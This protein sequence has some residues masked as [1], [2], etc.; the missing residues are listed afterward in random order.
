MSFLSINLFCGMSKS[1]P[2]PC[3]SLSLL[4]NERVVAE[5]IKIYISH[6]I[7]KQ[8]I[9]KNKNTK[10]ETIKQHTEMHINTRSETQER[11]YSILISSHLIS[12]SVLF[13]SVLSV[14]IHSHNVDHHPVD[15]VFHF[16]CLFDFMEWNQIMHV[17]YSTVVRSWL[18]C[19]RR[20]YGMKV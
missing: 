7:Q 4:W 8:T 3:T 14:V 11:M 10:E 13:C 18:W 1:Y 17:K 20:S 9:K 19:D 6:K 12:C 16:F 5:V 2:Y 15:F